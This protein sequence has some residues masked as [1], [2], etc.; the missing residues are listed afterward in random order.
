MAEWIVSATELA[1]LMGPG[2]TDADAEDM[3]D[4]LT[5]RGYVTRLSSN[6]PQPVQMPVPEAV[7]DDCLMSL[8]AIRGH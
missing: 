2:A 5:W 1:K 4:L 8:V 3:A 6:E 7:W